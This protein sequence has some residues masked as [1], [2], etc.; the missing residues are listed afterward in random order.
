MTPSRT[1]WAASGLLA[2]LVGLATS[3]LAAAVLSVREAPVVAVAEL[4]VRVTPGDLAERAISAVGHW[5]KPLLVSGIVIASVAVFAVAGI[6]GRRGTWLGM[7]VFTALGVVGLVAVL[8]GPAGTS[9]RILPVLVGWASWL[10]AY[11]WITAAL[12]RVRPAP[13]PGRGTPD[14]RTSGGPDLPDGPDGPIGPDRPIGTL[15]RRGFV[16]RGSLVGLVS[17]GVAVTGRLWGSGTRAVEEARRLIRLEGVTMPGIPRGA[18]VGLPGITPW[19]TPVEDFYQVHTAIVVP[20][21]D[22]NEWSLRIHGMVDRE[23]LLTYQ[24]LLEREKTEM[25]VTI[26]CV[27]NPVGGN[28]IGNAW[29][30]GV[31]I[32]D[33]LDMAGVRHG[34]DAVLQTSSDGW[35]CGTP[36]SALTDAREAILAVAMNGAPLPI[37]HGFPVRTIV[38][39]LYGYVSACKWVVDMEV[40][41]FDAIEAYWTSKGWA[42]EAPVKIASRVDLPRSGDTVP[43]GTLRVGGVAWAQHT[44]IEAVEVSLD[45]GDWVP[46][47]VGHVPTNDTWV[48]WAAV[49]NVEAGDHTLAVRA[50]D[51]RQEVQTGEIQDVLPDGATGWHTVDFT[52]EDA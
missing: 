20:K 4:I 39:G 21:I 9:T 33:L 26:N 47:Q 27:S 44:G 5:D 22:P 40:T 16:L 35:T 38:P 15:S 46:A 49:V 42:E 36:L 50:V 37:D 11:A 51:K 32:S 17:V 10:A 12:A 48:Q 25:W 2:G 7:L 31:R 18:R 8:T 28:L 13:S 14:P 24:Q 30:S 43:S 3:Y 19:R 41:R 52:A 34:A 29:W 1:A 23:V 6:L 45:Q